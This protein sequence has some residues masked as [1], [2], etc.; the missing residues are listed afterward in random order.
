[1]QA[2]QHWDNVY[3]NKPFDSVSWYAPHLNESIQLIQR[4]CP[5]SGDAI[6]DIGG[7]ESTLVDDLLQ[8]GYQD[9]AVLDISPE[10]IAF[11]QRR[12]GAKAQQVG[13][14]VADVTAY[15]FQEKKFDIWHDRAVF[16]FLRE[17]S[18]RDA[19]VDLVRR[20]VKP[21]GYVVM[22]TFGPNGPKQCSGLDVNRYDD[23]SLHGEFG[24]EF[25][26]LGSDLSRH[27]TPMGMEQEFLYCWC[28]VAAHG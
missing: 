4:L 17:K 20:S 13:W 9:L 22:A 16:H 26:L 7:G 2:I 25:E 15:D 11:T 1:M 10:A 12:L 3:R 8:M 19:Y 27:K 23:Q 5:R 21:G 18:A 6:I 28:R 24:D 14:H